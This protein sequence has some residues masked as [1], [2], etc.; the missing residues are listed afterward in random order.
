MKASLRQLFKYQAT[1]NHFFH[2][3]D[4][5]GACKEHARICLRC[6]LEN[7]RKIKREQ[8][9]MRTDGVL[10]NK[11]ER[12]EYI[13]F[14]RQRRIH[15]PHLARQKVK[16]VLIPWGKNRRYP[17]EGCVRKLEHSMV[18]EPWL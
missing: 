18:T 3:Q 10:L 6:W 4:Y 12:F 17:P 1:E 5:H 13:R 16:S 11:Q 8:G 2:D 14:F 9:R 7:L 15:C